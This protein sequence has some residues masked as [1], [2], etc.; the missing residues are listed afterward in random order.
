M[1]KI[2]ILFA[3]LMVSTSVFA[4]EDYATVKSVET[5]YKTVSEPMDVCRDE[6]VQDQVYQQQPQ[7]Y[8]QQPQSKNYGGAVIGGVAGGILGNQVGGGSG[9]TAATALGAVVGAL[10]GDNLANQPSGGNIQYQ[11]PVQQPQVISRKVRNCQTEYENKQVVSGY[12]V[13]AS[14]NG[15]PFTFITQ[16][17][18]VGKQIRVNVNVEPIQ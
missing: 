9:K 15:K 13:D 4:F 14:Y 5:Q 3:S 8:Q 6:I 18:P 2:S 12:K 10:V 16:E 1:K 17:K 11:Q 7:Q